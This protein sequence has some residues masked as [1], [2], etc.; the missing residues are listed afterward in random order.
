MLWWY[1]YWNLVKDLR[2]IEAKIDRLLD[3]GKPV[4]GW[5]V[6]CGECPTNLGDCLM[7]KTVKMVAI[8]DF[9][10]AEL[11]TKGALLQLFDA[12]DN[13]APLPTTPFTTAWSVGD[14][15]ILSVTPDPVNPAAATV[16]STGKIGTKVPVKCIVH[17]TDTPPSFADLDCECT[18]TVP[19][20]PATQGI[21]GIAP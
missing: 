1:W 16:S 8:P 13:P 7:A 21:I 4:R 10:M 6:L 15:T 2:R 17:A 12:G 5:I 20:G 19:A 18:I 14:S 9:N 3:R 11:A